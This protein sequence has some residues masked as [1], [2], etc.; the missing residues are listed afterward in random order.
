MKFD[1]KTH[2]GNLGD[3][4]CSPKYYFDF[5]PG[6]SNQIIGGGV[7]TRY[8]LGLEPPPPQ[9]VLWGVGCTGNVKKTEK[10]ECHDFLAWGVRDRLLVE[11]EKNFLPCVSALHPMLDLPLPKKERTL[12]YINADPRISSLRSLNKIREVASKSNVDTLTNRASEEKFEQYLS[13]SSHII[14]TSY[15]GAYWG[16]LSGRSVTLIG[17]SF[18]FKSLLDIFGLE[19]D[20][21]RFSKGDQES[22]LKAILHALTKGKKMALNDPESFRSS[23]REKQLL[24]ARHLE[25]NDILKKCHFKLQNDCSLVM[26]KQPSELW[27]MS[28]YYS[29]VNFLE[30]LRGVKNVLKNN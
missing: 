4:L 25:E 23:F 16:L 20:F 24:F 18:K 26:D 9:S 6:E 11:D 3:L 15:H 1:H 12:L 21:I 8:I 30:M 2:T 19:S 5:E 29:K 10:A 7:Q 27:T 28:K 17:Y 22:F 14:S 13:Q